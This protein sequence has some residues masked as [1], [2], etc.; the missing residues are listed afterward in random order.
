MQ[1]QSYLKSLKY[2]TK[3]TM[4]S[5]LTAHK[6]K[7]AHCMEGAFLAAAICEQLGYPPLVLSMESH[8]G[9]DHVMFVYK[10]KTGWGTVAMSRDYG[11]K[12]RKP[13]FRSVRDL[14]WSYYV[15]YIDLTGRITGYQV[16]SLDD[17]GVDWRNSS[18]SLWEAEDYLIRLKHIP[19]KSST[20]RYRDIRRRFI[21]KG[22]YLTGKHWL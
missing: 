13:Y 2:N 18:G 5:A 15:P 12:G 22:H 16:A 9:L 20:S 1:V 14:V 17:M 21:E 4:C 11:L 3:D 6:L 10:D 19:L 8:D 7:L